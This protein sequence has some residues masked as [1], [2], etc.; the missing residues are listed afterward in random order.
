MDSIVPPTTTFF[1]FVSSL[2]IMELPDCLLLKLQILQCTYSISHHTPFI[3]EMCIFLF[4][5]V[6]FG[7]WNSCIVGFV[8][9][10]NVL[11]E[12][13]GKV[14]N[15]LTKCQSRFKPRIYRNHWFLA[16]I[17]TVFC[18]C[19]TLVWEQCESSKNIQM[20]LHISVIVVLYEMSG[21]LIQ[22]WF[23]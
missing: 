2:D 10:I 22:T 16:V 20:C 7:I 6:Y 9:L 5:M 12:R 13:R 3:S 18:S 15:Y 14:R 11:S 17:I 8:K 19:L 4:W 23:G 21:T 1:K